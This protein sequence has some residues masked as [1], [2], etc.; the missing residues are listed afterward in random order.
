MSVSLQR[1]AFST[2][3]K[4]RLDYSFAFVDAGGRMVVQTFCQPAYPITI[5]RLVP[6][7]RLVGP[8]RGFDRV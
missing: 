2:N 7:P 4:T 1:T 6:R 5:G 8:G 3:V